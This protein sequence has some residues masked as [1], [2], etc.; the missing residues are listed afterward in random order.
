[1]RILRGA[2]VLAAIMLFL[3]S[4]V[5]ADGLTYRTKRV[6][7]T[8]ATHY[9]KRIGTTRVTHYDTTNKCRVVC[10]GSKPFLEY[11]EDGLALALDVPLA[12]L[13]PLTCPIV[14]PI[15]D[16]LDSDR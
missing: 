6:G 11:V 4:T 2:I 7:K 16:R 10:K 1:M 5:F 13:S 9:T 14:A 3:S 8:P 12:I 15:M